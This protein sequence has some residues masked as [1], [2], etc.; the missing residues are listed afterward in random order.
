LGNKDFAPAGADEF[1]VVQGTIDLAAI[2]PNEVWLLDFKTDQF[3][4]DQLNSKVAMYRPQLD[5][6]A[7]A[8]TKIYNRPVTRRWLRFL[9]LQHTEDLSEASS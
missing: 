8:I 5:L 9:S 6:Y 3:P 1:I 7:A 4:K 2:L